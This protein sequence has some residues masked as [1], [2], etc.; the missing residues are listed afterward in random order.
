MPDN[1]ISLITL[2][3]E[4]SR[5]SRR[6]AV[7]I[8]TL[9]SGILWQT[10]LLVGLRW[11]RA[12]LLLRKRWCWGCA[13]GCTIALV[14]VHT[15][16]LMRCIAVSS[17]GS[18]WAHGW[19]GSASCS[20]RNSRSP[21][22]TWSPCRSSGRWRRRRKIRGHL[23]PICLNHIGTCQSGR[24]RWWWRRRR[25][26]VLRNTCCSTKPQGGWFC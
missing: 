4:W 6:W 24:S 3:P 14:S 12:S 1:L 17:R 21:G 20:T 23:K 7:A 11:G 8:R 2:I 15:A 22:R 19:V 18:V 25:Q 26:S 16:W 9:G 10:S 5:W 13:R